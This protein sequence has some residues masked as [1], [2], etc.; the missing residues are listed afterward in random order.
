MTIY[1][2]W[3]KGIHTVAVDHETAYNIG[4][5]PPNHPMP[6]V[7]DY[8]LPDL[9]YWDHDVPLEY[10]QAFQAVI[11][12]QARSRLEGVSLP[13]GFSGCSFCDPDSKYEWGDEHG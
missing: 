6:A 3:T 8:G 10:E 13:C 5:Y 9:G 7:M 1:H 2:I 12:R 4:W 11:V